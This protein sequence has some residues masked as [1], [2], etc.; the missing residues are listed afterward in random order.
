[1][2]AATVEE[3]PSLSIQRLCSL[4][5]VSRSWYY[6]RLGHPE[7]ISAEDLVLRD[8]IEEIVLAFPGYGYRRVTH[9]L[10][11]DGWTV[12]H[13]RVLRIMRE[14]SLLCQLKRRFVATTDSQHG[15]RRYP[16]RIKDLVI[17]RLDQVWVAD[18]TYI[19][20]P[21]AFCYLAAILDAC[22]R[23][24][25]GWELSRWIDT[26][27]ALAA[28]ERAL[29]T[30][31]P[32]PGLIHHSDQGVQYASHDYVNRLEAAGIAISMA[33]KGNPYEN[34]RAERFFRTLKEEEV[35]LKEYQSI[36]EARANIGS[37][38]EDVYNVKRLHSALG[39]RPPSEFEAAVG[40]LKFMG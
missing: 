11:R 10:A 17:E 15:F 9:A 24:C 5:G 13:K 39:Y 38:I 30:R 26:A 19:R 1:V 21:T 16:N 22:S 37:F 6:E 29:W 18:I 25:V 14:E 3:Y 32:L 12:N 20:L 33:A 35:Y 8:A 34:A 36:E 7:A 31:R 2:I 27:L 40:C 4:L 28:L 23:R